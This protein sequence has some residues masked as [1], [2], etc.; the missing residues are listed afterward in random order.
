M[1]RTFGERHQF[2]VLV[3]ELREAETAEYCSAVLAFINC[4]IASCEDIEERATIRDDL[5]GNTK[6]L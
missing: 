5:A 4:F 1:Q 2:S 3:K 6:C